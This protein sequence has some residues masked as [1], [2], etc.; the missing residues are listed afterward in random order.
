M[1]HKKKFYLSA[2][3]ILLFFSLSFFICEPAYAKTKIT[4]NKTSASIYCGKTVSLKVKGISAK[5]VKWYMSAKAD[6]KIAT[7]NPKGVVKG[8]KPGKATVCAKIDKKVLKCKVK[9]K[10]CLKHSWVDNGCKKFLTCKQCGYVSSEYGSHK[11][12]A[13]TCAEDGYCS[14]CKLKLS[15]RTGHKWETV[16][17]KDATES[18]AGEQVERCRVCGYV[19]STSAIPAKGYETDWV[20]STYIPGKPVKIP[21]STHGSTVTS[22]MPEKYLLIETGKMRTKTMFNGAVITEKQIRFNEHEYWIIMDDAITDILNDD[23]LKMLAEKGYFTYQKDEHLKAEAYF[24]AFTYSTTGL[25]KIGGYFEFESLNFPTQK[26]RL[27]IQNPGSHDGKPQY[28]YAAAIAIDGNSSEQDT[29]GP[30]WNMYFITKYG[31]ADSFFPYW[32][33]EGYDNEL[34]PEDSDQ[35]TEWVYA[36]YT[37]PPTNIPSKVENG[38]VTEWMEPYELGEKRTKTMSD[39]TTVTEYKFKCLTSNSKYYDTGYVWGYFDEG[40]ANEMSDQV[41]NSLRKI[42]GWKDY[43]VDDTLYDEAKLSALAYALT[44]GSSAPYHY[45]T[46]SLPNVQNDRKYITLTN[47]EERNC[48]FACFVIDSNSDSG[49]YGEYWRSYFG[50]YYSSVFK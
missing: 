28:G 23:L 22:W 15:A 43:T 18:E 40:S 8:I 48:R 24:N 12:V 7:V 16:I 25:S 45:N 46:G 3:M 20:Y 13:A 27:K 47:G 41:L 19:F 39:G 30:I 17:T 34:T 11:E 14:R 1:V 37:P 35:E 29:Y 36:T 42:D 6:K 9:V 32:E 5:K 26:S 4:L 38:V 50:T 10:N 31:Y 49:K 33:Q 44:G 21:A 2:C